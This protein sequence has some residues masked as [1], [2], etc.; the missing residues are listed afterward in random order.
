[1]HR[2]TY[3]FTNDIYVQVL[4]PDGVQLLPITIFIK[5][6]SGH[7]PV[8]NNPLT[9]NYWCDPKPREEY[10]QVYF[11]QVIFQSRSFAF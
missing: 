1:M 2:D 5:H 8:T 7:F 10:K 4:L 9:M 3:N 11:F 6:T